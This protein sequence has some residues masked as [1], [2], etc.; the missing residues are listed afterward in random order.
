MSDAPAIIGPTDLVELSRAFSFAAE[1]HAAQRRK[2]EAKEPYVNHL[3]EVA[4]LVAYATGGHDPALVIAALLHDTVEDTPTTVA[5]LEAEFGADV[6][7]LVSEVTD[8]KGKPKG[9]RKRLQVENAPHKSERARL[10]KIAD[11]TSNLRGLTTSPPADWDVARK[12]E[13]FEWAAQVVEGCRG[14]NPW[15]EDTFDQAHRDGLS[16]LGAE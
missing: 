10:I 5:E 13:Y 14:V 12:R 6:A 8:D 3:A 4:W 15:L 2:G 1:R 9:E 7:G 16:A 11:K